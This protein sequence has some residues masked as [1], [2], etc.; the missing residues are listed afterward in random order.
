MPF[1]PE[2]C[3]HRESTPLGAD[4]GTNG[5]LTANRSNCEDCRSN[6]CATP[7][8]SKSAKV[9]AA[10]NELAARFDRDSRVQE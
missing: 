3:G 6:A 5:L 10:Y 1:P 2:S 7:V 8:V 9:H 4:P